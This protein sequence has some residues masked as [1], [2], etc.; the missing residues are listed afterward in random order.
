MSTNVPFTKSAAAQ[1]ARWALVVAILGSAMPGIDAT[2]VNV[3]LPILQRDLHASSAAIQWVVEG[4]SLFLSALILVGGAL[5]DRFGRR[6]MFVL[7]VVIFAL[8]SA[9]CAMSQSVVQLIIARCAQGLGGALLIPESLALITSAFDEKERGSAIGTWSGFSAITMAIGPL[10]GG[11]LVQSFS[12]RLIFVINLP[13]AA[14]VVFATLRYVAES[15]DAAD[16]A[17]VD[18]LGALLATTALGL[19]VF[20]FIRLQGAIADLFGLIAIASGVVLMAAFALVE[21]TIKA[22]M[23]SLQLF[24]SRNFSIANVYT[25]L[26]YSGLGGAFFFVPFDLI[27]VQG[28][29]PVEAGAALLPM[30]LIMFFASRWSGGLVART[31]PRAP[32]IIGAAIAAV[33]FVLFAFTGIGRNYFV[34]FFPA[35][36]VLG[37]GAAVFVAP[38]TT[39]V[40][41]AT[42]VAHAGSASGIN[43][44]ISRVAGLL[45]IVVFGIVI[46]AS[47]QAALRTSPSAAALPTAIRATLASNT[48]I[49]GR[50]PSNVP[51]IVEKAAQH[52]LDDA[53]TI[54]F[55]NVMLICAALALASAALGNL[56]HRREIGGSG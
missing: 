43:N 5:G 47:T 11:W 42:G 19:L 34:S 13:I 49:S 14:L 15:R 31:G 38:L 51:R 52:A 16:N 9:G 21:R 25:L 40:M 41:N 26:L 37:I 22:P 27:N 28:Y 3:A 46:V 18:W 8:A 29:T 48:G 24:A 33:G 45:A 12:W 2:A 54:G 1:S 6:R 56:T 36:F 10:L 4:Y 30:I 55:R 35:V 23:I 53:Y 7:G 39:T 17:P 20:G 44:A 32:L 50:V